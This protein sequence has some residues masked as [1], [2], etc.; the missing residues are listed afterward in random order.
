MKPVNIAKSFPLLRIFICYWY[1]IQKDLRQ[2]IQ[3]LDAVD[4]FLPGSG[5]PDLEWT[6]VDQDL[7]P[8]CIDTAPLIGSVRVHVGIPEWKLTAMR[9]GKEEV[10]EGG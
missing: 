2:R 9:L 5:S 7:M 4:P 1:W 3:T 8:V 6:Q 10:P